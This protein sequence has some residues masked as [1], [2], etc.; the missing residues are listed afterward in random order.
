MVFSIIGRGSFGTFGKDVLSLVDSLKKHTENKVVTNDVENIALML[1]TLNVDITQI[2]GDAK[3]NRISQLSK[4]A[5]KTSDEALTEADLKGTID[6]SRIGIFM[7]TTDGPDRSNQKFYKLLK[8]SAY[9]KANPLLFPETTMNVPASYVSNA[10]KITG[11]IISNAADFTSGHEIL[12]IAMNYLSYGCI[13]YALVVC[14]EEYSDFVRWKSQKSLLAGREANGLSMVSGIN[15][16]SVGDGASCLI[17]KKG[18]CDDNKANIRSI[19]VIRDDNLE[20][21]LS[22]AVNEVLSTAGLKPSEVDVVIK[23]GNRI[24]QLHSLET[25]YLRKTFPET[26]PILSFAQIFE[27]QFGVSTFL[28]IICATFFRQN[29]QMMEQ[30]IQRH[31]KQHLNKQVDILNILITSVSPQGK[32]G[33][34]LLTV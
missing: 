13:D 20:N 11:P 34:L 4:C 15:D 28:N 23:Q 7:G 22:L 17:I 25:N 2:M 27:E 18:N 33:A 31:Y 8:D 19:S 32:C 3:Y 5:I 24:S 12:E 1:G 14:A 26:I 30:Y 21:A 6:Y 29:I 9:K 16:D 10:H